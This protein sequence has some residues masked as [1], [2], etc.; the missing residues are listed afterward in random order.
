MGT[1]GVGMYEEV[2]VRRSEINP[3]RLMAWLTSPGGRPAQ[4]F[5]EKPTAD[6]RMIEWPIALWVSVDA[7]EDADGDYEAAI[8]EE[9]SIQ[10]QLNAVAREILDSMP[11]PSAVGEREVFEAFRRGLGAITD[12]T[13]SKEEILS[14]LEGPA[15]RGPELNE[16]LERCY[17]EKVPY[18]L[19][20]RTQQ[21]LL[22]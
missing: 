19:D 18:A 5:A 10:E 15:D 16:A 4:I 12:R 9:E 7:L 21:Y 22:F 3:D 1:A 13:V 20:E 6:R 2:Y 17:E 14:L 11:D 8:R